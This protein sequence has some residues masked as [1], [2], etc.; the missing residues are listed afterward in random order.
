MG[1]SARMSTIDQIP[2]ELWLRILSYLDSH[3]VWDTARLTKSDPVADT[4]IKNVSC[5]CRTMR[6]RT[7]PTLFT[8][9]NITQHFSERK[10]LKGEDLLFSNFLDFISGSGLQGKKSDIKFKIIVDEKKKGKVLF[11]RRLLYG[12][13]G[14]IWELGLVE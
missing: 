14:E 7:L 5:V 10:I 2:L 12:H 13:V 11:C 8:Y 1:T 9:I 3:E 4:P 6:I